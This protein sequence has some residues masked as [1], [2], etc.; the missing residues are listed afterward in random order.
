MRGCSAKVPVKY[1]ESLFDRMPDNYLFEEFESA[2]SICVVRE[3]SD[4][5][6]AAVCLSEDDEKLG[7]NTYGQER[8]E[9]REMPMMRA[10]LT[11]KAIRKAVIMPP[12]KTATQSYFS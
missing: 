9:T 1:I 7:R 3:E 8:M 11:R 4:G 10:Y 12:Q 5:G 2:I 6:V